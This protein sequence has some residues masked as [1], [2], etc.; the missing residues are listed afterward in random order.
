MKKMKILIIISLFFIGAG[1]F[2]SD[3]NTQTFGDGFENGTINHYL[4][5]KIPAGVT[6]EKSDV[7]K[8]GKIIVFKKGV[9]GT[10]RFEKVVV[11]PQIKYKLTFNAKVIGDDVIEKNSRINLVQV[12]SKNI[13][14]QWAVDFFDAEGKAIPIS[15]QASHLRL[16]SNQWKEYTTVFYTPLKA[17][18][19]QLVLSNRNPTNGME[20]DELKFGICPDEGAINCNP[21][22]R[23]GSYN[24]TGWK[25]I[26]SGGLLFDL[27]NGKYQ[28]D[29]AYG[30]I[31]ESFPLSVPGTYRLYARG[32]G[33]GRYQVVLLFLC[34]SKGQTLKNIVLRGAPEGK[35]VDFTLPEKTAFA[36]F[37]VYQHLLEEIRLTRLV[38]K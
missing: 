23:Y 7:L 13:L 33:Y 25:E 15:I 1:S 29:T 19:M 24:Y 11:K 12:A 22:F 36:Y 8:V 21:D 32:S 26:L 10:F 17:A 31:G 3:I 35:Y 27:G 28:F 4:T 5:G 14:W 37:R 38:I 16:V 30:S 2:A 6:I 9:I 18:Y 34:N 20:L